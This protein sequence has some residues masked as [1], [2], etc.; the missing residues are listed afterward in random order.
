LAVAIDKSSRADPT[1]LFNAVNGIIK[2]M[3]SDGTLS[4][5]SKKWYD[6]T[7]LTLKS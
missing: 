4:R 1:S 2:E 7:D 5:L 3:H 6:G